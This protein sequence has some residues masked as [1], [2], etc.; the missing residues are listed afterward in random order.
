LVVRTD[1]CNKNYPPKEKNG[2][3]VQPSPKRDNKTGECIAEP[4]CECEDKY[5][6]SNMGKNKSYVCM[7]LIFFCIKVFKFEIRYD[8]N[9]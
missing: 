8:L 6:L 1:F 9:F 2:K 4:L 5:V 3:C 7:K